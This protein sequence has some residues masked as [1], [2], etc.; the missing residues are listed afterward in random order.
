[1]RQETERK[2]QQVHWQDKE[3]SNDADLPHTT[4]KNLKAKEPSELENDEPQVNTG[5]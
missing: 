4:K 5:N 3:T 1:M 2:C